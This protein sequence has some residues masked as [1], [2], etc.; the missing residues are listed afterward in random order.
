MFADDFFHNIKN[1]S[2]FLLKK[3]TLFFTQDELL[4]KKN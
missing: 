2:D 3:Y 4:E 1:K